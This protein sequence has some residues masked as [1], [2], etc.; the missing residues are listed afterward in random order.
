MDEKA[1]IEALREQLNDWGHRYYVLDAPTVPDYEYDANSESWSS[2]NVRIR[3]GLRRIL[4][5]SGWE[6]RR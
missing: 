2:W 4:L 6:E 3:S 1:R 5:P